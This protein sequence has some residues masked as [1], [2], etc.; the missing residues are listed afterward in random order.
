[1]Q[2]LRNGQSKSTGKTLDIAADARRKYV[3][4]VLSFVCVE[5]LSPLKIVINC[6]N[7]AAGPTMDAIISSLTN[8]GALIEFIL[9]H[10]KPDATF[11]NGNS[12]P[13]LQKPLVHR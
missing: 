6:G 4:R 5:Q 9:V 8:R 13:I 11:P 7:G 12:N 1:M 3:D 10:H 2:R